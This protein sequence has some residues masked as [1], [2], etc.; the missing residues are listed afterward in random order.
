MNTQEPRPTPGRWQ[1][2]ALRAVMPAGFMM[3]SLWTLWL[4]MSLVHGTMTWVGLVAVAFGLLTSA[5][6]VAVGTAYR[7]VMGEG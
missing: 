1:R 5:A 3:F 6:L 7:R 2:L 4:V